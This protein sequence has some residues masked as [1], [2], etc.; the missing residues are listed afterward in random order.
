MTTATEDARRSISGPRGLEVDLPAR[1]AWV[2]SQPVELSALGFDMLCLL[3]DR[4]GDVVTTDDLAQLVWG[5][6]R[7][8]EPSYIHTAIYRLRTALNQ[9][10]ASGLIRNVRGVGYTMVGARPPSDLVQEPAVL[11]ATI[12][13]AQTPLAII[14]GDRRMQFANAALGAVLGYEEPELA[15]V[16]IGAA[17]APSAA[18][19]ERGGSLQDVMS[20]M[21]IL[22][23]SVEL[24][25]SNGERITLAAD[26]SPII[27]RGQVVA[28]L[29]EF[30]GA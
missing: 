23:R 18:D 22:G 29:A 26:L 21:Q 27:T 19:S 24:T 28:V 30:R 13:A 8:G 17:F 15:R 9:A 3:V 7:A 14:D 11:E 6:E 4:V 10:G 20:G 25:K 1:Q 5:H 12:R 2:G 16:D